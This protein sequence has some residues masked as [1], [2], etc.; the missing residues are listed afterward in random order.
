MTKEE[1][2]E[3]LN[4]NPIFY[5][6]TVAENKPH[7][8][9]MLMYRA[10]SNGIIFHT[11]KT[12]DL[13]RQLNQNPNVEMCF[14]NGSFESLIQIRVSG[15]AELLEDL[16]LKKEIVSKRDFLKPLIDKIGY[17]PFAVYRVRKAIATVWTMA[18]NLA[19]K[20]FIEL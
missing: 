4:A 1:I 19:P 20:E 2:F 18:T 14:T 15:K 9:G 16:D 10:D 8:R 17:E 11:G 12:K 7:V 5:L 3:F 13:H 6:A